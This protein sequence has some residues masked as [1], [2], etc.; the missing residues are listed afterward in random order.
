MAK[1]PW[2]VDET[3]PPVRKR[4]K[5][6]R[7]IF[8]HFSDILITFL[9]LSFL[10]VVILPRM[11]VTV[12]S[13]QVGV[14][15]KRFNGLGFQ[16]WCFVGRGTVLDPRELRQ[17]G[18]HLIWPWDNVFTYDLRLQSTEKTYNAISSDGVGLKVTI[19]IRFQLKNDS[20]A[21]LH[22]Y[23]GPEYVASVVHP[24]IGSRARQVIA[25]RTAEEA[26]RMRAQIEEDIK[27]AALITLGD[28]LNRLVQP[29][30]SEQLDPDQYSKMLR[31]SIKLFDTLLLSIELPD[32]VVAAINRK[33]EQFYQIEE[34][35]YRIEKELK[36]TQRKQIEAN[37]I[38]AFQ[39]TVSEGISDSYLRW[40]GIEATLR[41]AES[42]NAKIV[43]IGGGKEGLPIILGNMDTPA[44]KPTD[45]QSTGA[46]ATPKDKK[47]AA[48]SPPNKTGKL[49]ERSSS[50]FSFSDIDVSA[51]RM[52]D[53]LRSIGIHSTASREAGSKPPAE[54]AKPETTSPGTIPARQ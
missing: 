19:N 11:I 52:L 10:T 2:S 29:D 23:V 25:G 16:C 50:A 31:N 22:K 28:N 20:V 13:G 3:A 35:Q 7:Y 33:A 40:R 15:W 1:F 4:G 34:Y 12:P 36:E 8:R 44:S 26:Y 43:I 53:K 39:K 9:V 51:D 45:P 42:N 24:E 21:V 17:E 47:P 54:Q 38:A 27:K 32:A 18:L 5:V 30:A 37:G 6:W 41:L 14:L 49:N 48:G 46:D